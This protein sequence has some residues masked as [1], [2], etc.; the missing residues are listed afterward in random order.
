MPV[1]VC[2]SPFVQCSRR[3][4]STARAL[5][6]AD[7]NL[8]TD[9][10]KQHLA[11]FLH[12]GHVYASSTALRYVKSVPVSNTNRDGP[13]ILVASACVKDPAGGSISP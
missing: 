13:R 12:Q 9:A 5:M 11:S 8:L 2:S 7:L 6:A 10:D 4:R 3:R 1:A